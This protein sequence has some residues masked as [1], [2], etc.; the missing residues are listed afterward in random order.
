MPWAVADGAYTR[1]ARRSGDERLHSPTI[2]EAKDLM[3]VAWKRAGRGVH[4]IRRWRGVHVRFSVLD[5]S[6]LFSE[7]SAAP[8]SCGQ[9]GSRV[10]TGGFVVASFVPRAARARGWPTRAALAAYYD[11]RF[12]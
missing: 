10:R 9:P 2:D 8:D 11:V 6:S 1:C 7:L 3:D 4:C 5:Q 12:A